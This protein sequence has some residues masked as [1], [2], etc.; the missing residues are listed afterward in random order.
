MTSPPSKDD[1]THLTVAK[2]AKRWHMSKNAVYV[3]RH[4]GK[5]P[6]GFKSGKTVLF[7]LAE[8]EAWE[9]ERMA[10]DRPSHRGTTVEHRPPERAARRG[11][12][13]AARA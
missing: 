12:P 11:R 6:R 7:P 9:A 4:R 13:S 1:P 5:A 2:L 10:A 3:A 8:V